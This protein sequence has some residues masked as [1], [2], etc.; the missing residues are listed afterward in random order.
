MKTSQTLLRKMGEFQVAQRTSDGDE[1]RHARKGTGN[2]T[3]EKIITMRYALRNQQKIEQ[4]YSKEILK[5]IIK[6]L[7]EHFL[8]KEE[9]EFVEPEESWEK[10]PLIIINDAGHSCALIVF[11]VLSIKYD[12]IR[13]AYKEFVG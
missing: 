7:D 2:S 9:I 5:R 12:V 10:L 4:A 3:I 1:L 13:L 6:S 11:Y 8:G